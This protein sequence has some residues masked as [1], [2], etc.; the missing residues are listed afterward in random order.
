VRL[1]VQG[2]DTRVELPLVVTIQDNGPGIPED[3]RPHLFDPFVTTKAH[4]TGLGL[5][6]VA[7]IIGDHGGVIEFD[8]QPRRTVFRVMLPIAAAG[9][10][11]PGQE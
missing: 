10:G 6:L 7:K 8:S 4:G 2:S 1:A 5:A 3:I 11:E 9:E